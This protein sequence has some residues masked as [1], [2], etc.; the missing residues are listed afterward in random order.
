MSLPETTRAPKTP[1]ASRT[2]HRTPWMTVREDDFV[3]ADGVPG[4]F[5]VVTRA[6]FVVV[7]CDTPE[8]LLM[9]EQ[10][11][12]AAARW[13]LEL[14][15]GGLEPGESAAQAA[16]RELREETGWHGGSAE[17]LVEGLY[18]AADWAT[19]RFAVVRVRGG[20]PGPASPEP[21]EAIGA[22]RR[23]PRTRLAAHVLVSRVIDAATLAALA[24]V[25]AK[26]AAGV[27]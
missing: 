3:R 21:D 26:S 5:T 1:R 17:I 15:Q 16:L 11:R 14:P 19:Q 25:S 22:V 24:V 27:S 9:T 23:V 4:Q 8:G 18:E 10:Y 13:S 12:Y 7:L 20:R 6:D 2:V